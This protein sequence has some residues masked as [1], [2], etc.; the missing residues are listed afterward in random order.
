MQKKIAIKIDVDTKRGYDIGVP[1]MLH[2]FKREHVPATFFFPMG[3]DNSGKAIRRIFRKGFLA[4]MLRTKAPSTYG[5]KTMLYGTILPAPDIIEPNPFPF[6]KAIEDGHEV[7]IH[8]WDHVYWQDKLP[9]L[10]LEQIRDELTKAI[11]QF[12]KIA[13]FRPKAC[14]AP[15]WQLTPRSLEVQ[16]ELGFDY[17]SDVRGYYPFYP[18]MND[19]KYRTLQIPGTLLTM[20]ECLGLGNITTFNIA[21]FWLEHCNQAWNVLTIHSEMEGMNNLPQLEEFILKAKAQGY[22]FIRL[23]EGKHC[24]HIQIEEVYHGF[25]P[26]RAGTVARQRLATRYSNKAYEL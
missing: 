7:G 9:E 10:S 2:L 16:D 11:E 1:R 22:T 20:D 23:E 13:G 21:D 4:K 17:A 15:G 14:A 6:L 19:I 5:L 8:C 24:P 3:R 25:L 18:E 26:G 12:R